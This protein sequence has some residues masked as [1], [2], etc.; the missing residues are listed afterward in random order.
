VTLASL[1]RVRPFCETVAAPA[2]RLS[3]VERLI[4]RQWDRTKL[5]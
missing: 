5:N 4:R 1:S 3:N 2:L